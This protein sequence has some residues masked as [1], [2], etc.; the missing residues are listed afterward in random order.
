MSLIA[1]IFSPPP[2][3]WDSL[4]RD[5]STLAP[6]RL[7]VQTVLLLLYKAH[8]VVEGV[9]TPSTTL[10]QWRR[11]FVGVSWAH[12][13]TQLLWIDGWVNE[14]A[15]GRYLVATVDYTSDYVV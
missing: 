6:D 9:L 3:S 12:P 7:A 15:R 11:L 2:T 10:Q 4:M 5:S 1:A 14:T 13:S 8:H